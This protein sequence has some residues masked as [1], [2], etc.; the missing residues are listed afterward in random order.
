MRRALAILMSAVTALSAEQIGQNTQGGGNGAATFSAAAQLVIETVVVTD[1]SGKP[2]EGLTHWI[3]HN[4]SHCPKLR[5]QL[6]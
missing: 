6:R 1:K 5:N 3:T 2:V 4:G